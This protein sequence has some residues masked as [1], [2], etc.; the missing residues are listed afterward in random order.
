M[1]QSNNMFLFIGIEAKDSEEN[2]SYIKF[3]Y[4][5][6]PFFDMQYW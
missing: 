6:S 5:R 4:G 2:V 3:Q 1:W